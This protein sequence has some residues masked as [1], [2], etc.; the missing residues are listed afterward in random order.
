MKLSATLGVI[1]SGVIVFGY[2]EVWGAD[3]KSCGITDLYFC[4]YDAQS[5]TR[6]SKNI[7]RV[8]VKWVYTEKGR[9]DAQGTLAKDGYLKSV[10]YSEI[11]HELD[12]SERKYRVLSLNYYN[13]SGE[14]IVEF[15]R[16][17]STWDFIN[18]GSILENL[19]KEVCK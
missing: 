15:A 10:D 13:F 7:V 16:S 2:A 3:W 9:L 6:P 1:L 8:W 14:S 19:Y 5:L 4:F 18:P 17:S 12:C 11:L